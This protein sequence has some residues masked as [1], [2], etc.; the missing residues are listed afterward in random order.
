[1]HPQRDNRLLYSMLGLIGMNIGGIVTGFMLRA[2]Q[3]E[4]TALTGV[5]HEN[6][7]TQ[8][9]VIVAG[10]IIFPIAGV[11]YG[12]EMGKAEMET[13]AIRQM[14]SAHVPMRGCA[15]VGQS[16]ALAQT[17][18]CPTWAERITGPA[19]SSDTVQR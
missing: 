3:K 5:Q 6:I 16:P 10:S 17:K 9:I 19:Q 8:P 15:E 12:Y 11:F 13:D 14:G 2:K 18:S 1:M 7:W 4:L